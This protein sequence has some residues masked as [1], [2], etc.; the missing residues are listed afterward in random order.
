MEFYHRHYITTDG[1]G[2]VVE[3]WSDGPHPEK[4]TTKAVLLTE[5]GDYQ[6]RLCG[7][8]NPAL[9]TEEGIPLYKWDGFSVVQRTEGEIQ[10]DRAALPPAPPA[11]GERIAALEDAICEQ[12]AATAKRLDD[13]ENALCE[14]DTAGKGV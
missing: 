14:M 5:Q 12:D 4:D 9:T 10:A 6:F 8:W 7:L 13:I 1:N 3:G 11:D 2:R